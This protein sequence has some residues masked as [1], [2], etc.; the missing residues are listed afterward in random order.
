MNVLYVSVQ[1]LARPGGAR[2]HVIG[3]CEALK[4]RG[5]RVRLLSAYGPEEKIPKTGKGWTKPIAHVWRL[6]R[7]RH[8]VVS[9]VRSGWPDI[10]YYRKGMID[11][12]LRFA[13][14]R[15]ASRIFVEMNGFGM[16]CHGWRVLLDRVYRTF[17]RRTLMRADLVVT[18]SSGIRDHL[19]ARC[20]NLPPERTIVM[21]NGVD[22]GLFSRRCQQSCRSRIG[23]EPNVYVVTFVGVLS[24]WHGLK[25]VLNAL[26]LLK[27]RNIN[28]I[29]LQV[30]GD[31]PFMPE[32]KRNV[33]E[34]HLEDMVI[35]EGM[36][37][38]DQIP[39]YIGCSDICVAPFCSE[40]NDEMGISPLKIFEYISCG[41][42]VICSDVNGISDICG[43]I[44]DASEIILVK[45]DDPREIAEVLER[46]IHD[47][48]SYTPDLSTIHQ[49]IS[50]SA[51]ADAIC[52]YL[53][54]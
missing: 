14:S 36:V 6:I 28:N 41:K 18:V 39:V 48:N 26:S 9:I 31:G 35:F 30:V 15:G 52:S 4:R 1:N 16:D 45:P 54:P 3:F 33:R 24:K 23:I 53:K 47:R 10:L 27:E 19:L 43:E 20:R 12:G 40:R 42:P 25:T 17:E 38:Q 37:A 11:P 22:V 5:I 50:W 44:K 21:N 51:R 34:T 7:L 29:R 8:R 13:A 32:L 2:S 46:K 49:K